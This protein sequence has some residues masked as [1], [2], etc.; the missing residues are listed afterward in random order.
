MLINGDHFRKNLR[1]ALNHLY[2]REY[3]RRS[4]LVAIFHLAER[5]DAPAALQRLLVDEIESL[6]PSPYEA[7]LADRQQVYQI[8]LYRYIQHFKQD[9]VA[10]HLG[11]SE[12]QFR[13]EQDKALDVLASRLWRKYQLEGAPAPTGTAARQLPDLASMPAD[14]WEWVKCDP[15]ERVANPRQVIVELF[16]LIKPVA[17]GFQVELLCPADD[18]WPDLA[19]H[20]VAF[21]QV[22][23]NLLT[24]AIHRAIG[25][26]VVVRARASQAHLSIE[27]EARPSITLPVGAA[28]PFGDPVTGGHQSP[29]DQE[30]S[31]LA[32]AAHL[33]KLCGG[34]LLM[35][36]QHGYT[37]HLALPVVENIGV[38]VLDDN[39]DI[40]AL[41]ERYT[42]DSRYTVIGTTDPDQVFGLAS[43]RGAKIIVLDVMMP[44]IDG[45]ELLGRLRMHPLT[46][47]LPVVIQTILAQEDLALTLG[48]K[49]LILKPVTQEKFLA[50]LDQV[51][52]DQQSESR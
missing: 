34:S 39:P 35:D 29:A 7:A 44:K 5:F 49:A 41:L 25:G 43:S 27:I 48:A 52:A 6:K 3:L 51:L 47:H 26:E 22:V 8:L 18:R 9:E 40:L 23:L 14:E 11:I 16:R 31:L 38:L 42:A 24:V 36:T 15:T 30:S 28:V 1:G 13:R 4:P 21:R 17:A 32:I 46:A 19:A 10:H 37:A 12:R 33:V 2:D 45:W 50:V 20:P